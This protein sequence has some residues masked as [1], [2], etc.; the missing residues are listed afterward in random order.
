MFFRILPK[1]LFLLQRNNVPY[2]AGWRGYLMTCS[3]A[4]HKVAVVK[5]MS[6]RLH[7]ERTHHTKLVFYGHVRVD[8]G[9][10]EIGV[11]E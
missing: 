7:V 2:F 4:G 11:A 5:M 8:H 1:H 9:G 6:C 10:L 3:G